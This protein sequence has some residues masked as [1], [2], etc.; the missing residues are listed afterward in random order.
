M[1]KAATTTAQVVAATGGE[2]QKKPRK[3]SDVPRGP[4]LTW[5]DARRTAIAVGIVSGA[6]NLTDLVTFLKADP[7]FSGQAADLVNPI[8]VANQIKAL[9]KAGVQIP[10]NFG[11]RKRAT[12]DV[13]ALNEVLGV[14]A[15][16]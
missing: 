1:A 4:S 10:E 14:Q 6:Q 11:G 5:N 2:V 3:H 9:R 13:A 12:V 8:R 16:A 7:A 15:S